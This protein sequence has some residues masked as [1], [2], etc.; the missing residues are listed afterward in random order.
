MTTPIKLLTEA[1][2]QHICTWWAEGLTYGVIADK[3]AA[4]TG[5]DWT[6]QRVTYL[7]RTQGMIRSPEKRKKSTGQPTGGKGVPHPKGT[8]PAVLGGFP[9]RA[10]RRR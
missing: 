4:L 5:E 10:L 6:T 3:L 1:Q 8:G 7:F 9:I 2:F